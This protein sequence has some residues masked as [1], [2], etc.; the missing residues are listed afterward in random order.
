MRYR[1]A[2]VAGATYFFTVNLA[3][4]KRTV[5]VDHVDLL[6]AVVQKV[7]AAYRCHIDAMVILPDHLHAVWTLPVG[8]CGYAIRWMLIKPGFSRQLAKANGAT[9]AASP[10]ANEE[11]GNGDIGCI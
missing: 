5:P 9:K 3:E 6:R 1:R 4:W 10:K 8:D 7:M 11:Y 2:T